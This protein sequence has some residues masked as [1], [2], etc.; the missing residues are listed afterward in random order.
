[1]TNL[2]GFLITLLLLLLMFSYVRQKAA[3]K[4]KW[5]NFFGKAKPAEKE[6]TKEIKKLI[7]KSYL[8]DFVFIF[9]TKSLVMSLVVSGGYIL[10]WWFCC[11]TF[12]ASSFAYVFGTVILVAI[13]FTAL[14]GIYQSRFSDYFEAQFPYA[15]RLISR[16]LAVG[17]T[18]YA[19]IDAAAENLSDIMKREFTRI[20]FQLKNG[21]SFD[22][23]LSRGEKIYPY[24]GY[25]VFSSYI[26]I[27]IQKGSSLKDTLLSLANDLVAAQVIKKKTKA[28]TSEARGAAKIL[29]LLPLLMLVVLYKFAFWNF[30]YLFDELYGRYVVI[31]V[32]IS[33]SIGF[34]IISRMI[35]GVEL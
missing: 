23:I 2:T 19:A 4:K 30:V 20:S 15:L 18:I 35:K 3:K 21:V 24:K 22:D 31:Y 26:R 7:G 34:F 27:S 10:F 16:N 25:F 29:A 9:G 33:V 5:E 8:P 11:L 12:S 6:K 32:V 14:Y 13:S 28:L 1:M 17:Q